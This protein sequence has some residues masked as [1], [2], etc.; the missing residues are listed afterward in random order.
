LAA[1]AATARPPAGEEWLWAGIMRDSVQTLQKDLAR[2]NAPF[3]KVTPPPVVRVLL[4]NQGGEDAFAVA[5]DVIA[6]DLSAFTRYGAARKVAPRLLAQEYTHLLVVPYLE[7]TGWSEASLE[8]QPYL[9]AL[10]I[11]YYEGLGNLRSIEGDARYIAADGQLTAEARDLLAK[12]QPILRERMAALKA[13]PPPD[14]AKLLL[15]DISQGLPTDKWGALPIALKLAVD[16]RFQPDK[17]AVW[18]EKGPE[19]MVELI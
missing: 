4:G 5:P 16:T 10:R 17:L 2:L 18:V 6:F 3:R 11:L 7:S 14:Q 8:N 13:N 12:L 1:I 9:L 19:G 15:R